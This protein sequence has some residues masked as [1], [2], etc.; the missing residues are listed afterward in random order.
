MKILQK[1]FSDNHKSAMFFHGIIATKDNYTLETFQDGEIA[2]ED[3][4]YV[5]VETPELA[6]LDEVFDNDIEDELIVE[7]YV[8]KFIVIKYKG[9]LISDELMF[10]NYDE[11]MQKFKYYLK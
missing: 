5:G 9:E 11:A 1:P 4:I 8:D 10:D 2:Y 3:K 7:I 6:K